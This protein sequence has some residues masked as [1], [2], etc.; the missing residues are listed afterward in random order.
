MRSK[1]FQA[2]ADDLEKLTPHQ[3][4][5]LTERLKKIGHVQ[6]GVPQVRS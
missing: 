1:A 4:A 6:A 3:S 5:L 2:L